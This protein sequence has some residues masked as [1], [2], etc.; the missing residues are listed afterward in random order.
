M[1]AL[2]QSAAG[3][4]EA[5]QAA[6]GWLP[7]GQKE[8]TEVSAF[9]QWANGPAAAHVRQVVSEL[10]RA[11][12]ASSP[13]TGGA[14]LGSLI[15]QAELID[16]SPKGRVDD[17]VFSKHRDV[18][19]RITRGCAVLR[20]I[21]ATAGAP[22]ILRWAIRANNKFTGHEDEGSNVVSV[23]QGKLYCVDN[24]AGPATHVLVS[25]KSNGSVLHLAA[26]DIDIPGA[27]RVRWAFLG[28]KKVHAGA[29][30]ESAS[31]AQGWAEK[32]RSFVSGEGRYEYVSEMLD[33]VVPHLAADK[34]RAELVLS[35]L[36]ALRLTINAEYV[37][38]VGTG[39][40]D[41]RSIYGMS[42]VNGAGDAAA[43]KDAF[44]FVLTFN[45]LSVAPGVE[46]GLD[47]L[48]GLWLLKVRWGF[49]VVS[50][51]DI[52][53]SE[54]G[55]AK[56][57]VTSLPDVEGAVLYYGNERGTLQLE[58][59]KAAGYVILRAIREK[60]KP[61]IFGSRN[62]GA[63][64][65][66]LL[67]K[68]AAEGGHSNSSNAAGPGLKV[69]K[70]TLTG[71]QIAAQ[72]EAVQRAAEAAPV[73]A[74]AADAPGKKGK[75]NSRQRKAA[76]KA[77]AAA[78]LN[79]ADQAAHALESMALAPAAE[80][81]DA[82]QSSS[83]EQAASASASASAATSAAA[84]AA[85][86]ADPT[87]REYLEWSHPELDLLGLALVAE[88]ATKVRG[89]NV[90]RAPCPASAE[91]EAAL[92]ARVAA[93]FEAAV[94]QRP[95]ASALR[96]VTERVLGRIRAIDHVPIS[97]EERERWLEDATQF[98]AWIQTQLVVHKRWPAKE[99]MNIY[100]SLWATF[101][102]EREQQQKQ[103]QQQQ[104]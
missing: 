55:V 40:T 35:S 76:A 11:V 27:G 88:G 49:K 28:S 19:E 26:R 60:L 84:A 47:P 65:V 43:S 8:Q 97:A 37:S 4:D 59:W 38:S 89:S 99:V 5:A 95:F 53:L 61:F 25:H 31:G 73:G 45:V 50:A 96:L 14:A 9:L 58:K 7:S 69:N 85:T 39:P 2:E 16:L 79:Q 32:M 78:A 77:K 72:N 103:R 91:E 17:E 3:L 22:P 66:D 67:D 92:R 48:Y 98:L 68:M 36:A 94:L 41:N 21:P 100:S 24:G 70:V 82:D 30:W 83:D 44:G 46:L 54:L 93:A 90:W 42:D 52:P 57:A 23:E 71:A 1:A 29:V 56:R 10:P 80:E 33:I 64:L 86:A 63:G 51:F 102:E 81:E 12:Y 74:P 18:W 104:R 34:A 101:R 87:P 75:K 15:A 62:G 13:L 6:A 20:L